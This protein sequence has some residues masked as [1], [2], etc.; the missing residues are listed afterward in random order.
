MFAPPLAGL[1]PVA[2]A[3]VAVVP[4]LDVVLVVSVAPEVVDVVVALVVDLLAVVL[5][6][7]L[8]ARTAGDEEA[9]LHREGR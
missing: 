5:G 9:R 3:L 1:A 2:L 7:P 8:E 4:E 6:E